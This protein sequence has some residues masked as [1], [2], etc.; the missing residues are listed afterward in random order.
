MIYTSLPG[1]TILGQM[2]GF[3]GA[4]ASKDCATPC[5]NKR[6]YT[7]QAARMDEQLLECGACACA[8]NPFGDSLT[9]RLS[10]WL[11]LLWL[12][13]FLACLTDAPRLVARESTSTLKHTR[14][15]RPSNSLQYLF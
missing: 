2:V 14:F 7:F 8:D 13:W 10:V 4:I 9:S 15:I 5:S 6:T 11:N 1:W 12:R 3:Q